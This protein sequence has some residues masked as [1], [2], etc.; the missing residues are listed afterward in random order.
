[1]CAAAPPVRDRSFNVACHSAWHALRA[2]PRL[3]NGSSLRLWPW[4]MLLIVLGAAPRA[5]AIGTTPP[6]WKPPETVDVFPSTD[7]LNGADRMLAY[8]H[9]GNPAVAYTS[10]IDASLRYARRVPGVGWT[11]AEIASIGHYPSLAFDRYER[12]AISYDGSGGIAF[13]HFDGT[14]WQSETL[15]PASGESTALAFDRLGRPAIAYSDFS[16]FSLKYVRDTDGDFSFLDETPVTVSDEVVEGFFPSLAFDPLNRAMIAHTELTDGAQGVR[17][18]V[19]EPGI[20]WVTVTVDSEPSSQPI[21]SLAIDPDTGHPAI[22]Y[23]GVSAGLQFAA[24]DGDEWVITPVDSTADIGSRVSL[25]FDPADGNPA[26]S[27]SNF[28]V[29]Q[30]EFA[31]HDGS[32]WQTQTVASGALVIMQSSLAFN[33]FGSGFPSIVYADDG[34]KLHFIDDPPA[35]VPEPGTLLLLAIGVAAVW[36]RR[37]DPCHNNS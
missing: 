37:R 19:E 11:D 10:N 8:D 17:F 35:L 32:S 26:I 33:D 31:W 2:S 24:W 15:G 20:G 13:A 7:S 21:P 14:A 23:G 34:N 29:N 22:A 28:A 36:S 16:D 27:Y 25:A 5:P 12:P 30:L 3:G 4:L 6:S 18:S 9:H 1:M